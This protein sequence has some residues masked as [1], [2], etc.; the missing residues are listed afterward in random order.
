MKHGCILI[1]FD[2]YESKY[3]DNN[4]NG[5]DAEYV[6]GYVLGATPT[7]GSASL[8]RSL[9]KFSRQSPNY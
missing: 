5:H 8:Q 9:N 7:V 6:Q 4:S 1:H 2:S 3:I